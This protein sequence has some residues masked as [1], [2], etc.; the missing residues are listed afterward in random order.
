MGIDHKLVPFTVKHARSDQAKYSFEHRFFWFKLDLNQIHNRKL[1]SRNRFSIYS[2][3]DLD[4][5]NLGKTNAR[6][7][8]IEFAK[9]NG[10]KEEIKDIVLYTQLR[11]FNYVFNP[12]S[13]VLMKDINDKEYAIIEVNN[14][15]GE[16]KPFFVDSKYF[17]NEN[18]FKVNVTKYFYISP[19][20]D[21]DNEM[22]FYFTKQ[23][24]DLR[25]F[26]DDKKN[27][28][29]VLKV[30]FRG[31]ETCLNFFNLFFVSLMVP[32]STFKTIVLIHYHALILFLKGVKYF[33]K[34]EHK[35]LQ[36][37]VHT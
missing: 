11:M 33:K 28:K 26:I 25:I 8:F 5:I 2:F 19:F 20:I 32:F 12:V 9:Q 37:G 14:T 7:N 30:N 10:L 22:E 4:H 16:T 24:D 3:Y 27:S 1:F 23:Y 35:D 31:N 13:F 18:S 29:S 21:H 36:R 34:S 17:N 15:F 6:E